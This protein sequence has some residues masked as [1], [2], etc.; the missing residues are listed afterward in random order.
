[1]SGFYDKEL[2]L[3]FYSEN[4]KINLKS[5]GNK[6]L[7]ILLAG[8]A[9]DLTMPIFYYVNKLLENKETDIL[10][11]DFGYSKNQDFIK[12]SESEQDKIFDKDVSNLQEYI[13]SLDYEEFMFIG[14]SL[15]TSACYK[16]LHSENIYH[17]TKGA[18]WL[19]PGTSAYQ[20]SKFIS[21][22]DINNLLIYGDN[23]K[24]KNDLD[25]T[26]LSQNSFNLNL[27]SIENANHSLES[28]NCV[29]SI[30]ILKYVI[31][32]INIFIKN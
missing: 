20:I 8:F 14:K 6:R 4:S 30:N 10:Q 25:M 15:G 31:E 2:N 17:R 16:L 22:N 27:I 21:K 12:L 1:M 3:S 5:N 7:T 9:Y 19:T 29:E 26:A 13:E 32:K 18:I 28:N 24:Y 23:D 11:I